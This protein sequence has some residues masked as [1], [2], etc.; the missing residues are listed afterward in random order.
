MGHRRNPG[1]RSGARSPSAPP[2]TYE[3]RTPTP[4]DPASG[5]VTTIGLFRHGTLLTS[6]TAWAA[7][8]LPQVRDSAVRS[9]QGPP[10]FGNGSQRR[11]QRPIAS[12]TTPQGSNPLS[13]ASRRDRTIAARPLRRD[14]VF[15]RRKVETWVSSH[16][17]SAPSPR[18][19]VLSLARVSTDWR[20]T[21]SPAAPTSCRT[22]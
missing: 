9:R 5:A 21:P 13:A 14:A 3:K 20:R 2:E 12:E 16:F 8:A 1:S 19:S 10:W 15:V 7:F 6:W 11:H 22:V 17:G 4:A 18:R